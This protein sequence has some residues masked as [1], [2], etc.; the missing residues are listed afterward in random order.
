[1]LVEIEGVSGERWQYHVTTDRLTL[2]GNGERWRVTKL[3]GGSSAFYHRY[4]KEEIYA[5]D[6]ARLRTAIEVASLREVAASV[7]IVRLLDIYETADTT[8]EWAFPGTL[9]AIWELAD[10]ALDEFLA[11]PDDDKEDVAKQVKVNVGQALDQ[12]HAL[13]WIHLDVAPN[14][15]LR[16]G[17]IWKLADL[18]S[19]TRRGEPVTRTPGLSAYIHPK[20][21]PNKRV[22]AV[23]E[24]D[25]FGLEVMV[26]ALRDR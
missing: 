24:F 6:I 8:G 20:R 10:I 3:R 19:C 22:D 17:G 26:K 25:H 15:V 18:D 4:I 13:G 7:V 5:D 12:L 11:Y 16:V 9:G 1:M 2:S 21:R 23:D 14:N